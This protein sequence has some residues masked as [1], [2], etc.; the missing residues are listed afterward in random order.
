VIR[1]AREADRDRFVIL[2]GA[3]ALFGELR[4]SNRRRVRLDPASQL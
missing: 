4:K 1:Q 2:A 3:A